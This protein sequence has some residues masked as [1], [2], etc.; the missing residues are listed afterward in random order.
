MSQPEFEVAI[1][2]CGFGGM[3]AAIQL[4]RMGVESLVMIDREDDLGGT[5]HVNRYPGLAVDIASLTY[6][7]SFEPNP[8]WSHLYARGHELKEYANHVA[9]KYDLRRHMRFGIA[10]E[11]AHFDEKGNF[12]TL[13]PE[14]KDPITARVL[15]LATGFLSQPHT[16]DIEGIESFKGKVI[17]TADWDGNYD[18]EGKRA[19]VIGTGATAVQLI[20]TI[21]PKLQQLDVYQRTP[22]WVTPKVDTPIPKVV[23]NV[24][25][26]LPVTQKG[27]RLISSGILE[28]IMVAGVLHN[29]KLPA[30]TRTMERVCKAHMARTIKD[31][32]LREKLT[33]K[34]SFGCKRPTFSNTYYP[35]FNRDNVAL[36]TEGIARIEENAIVSNDGQRREIDTLILATGFDLWEENFPA[37]EVVGRNQRNLGEWWRE[38][39]FKAYQGVA[40]PGFPNLFSLASPYAY[41][42]LSFFST[43]EGQMKHINRCLGEMIGR[44]AQTFEVTEEANDAFVAQMKERVQKSLFIHG[45]CGGSNSYYYNQHGEATLLRPTS[46]VSGLLAQQHFPIEAYRFGA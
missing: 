6:S 43:I 23:Q 5:W 38:Q 28:T 30:L 18:L 37:F 16:P 24:F 40:I 19:A 39:G 33:P 11:K 35:T 42:G 15:I 9:E 13:Y 34:Y 45:Q 26:K 22:I 3:G 2:G 21:A 44:D 46:T 1:V 41:N 36:V 32:T 27:A 17:H 29:E 14:G 7:Y 4:R 8:Y 20:P 10:V 12:W 25:A 31:K